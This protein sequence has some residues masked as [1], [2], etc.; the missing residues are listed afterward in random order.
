MDR[1]IRYTRKISGDEANG[2][3]IMVMKDSL[4]LFPKPGVPF[5]IKI[6]DNEFDSQ[7][8]VVD[9]WCQGPKKPHVHY[10]ID[11]TPMIHEFRPHYGQT[12]TLE[13]VDESVYQFVR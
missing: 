6:D 13:K 3:Y 5:K 8:L 1:V 2:R 9:C 4:K 12:V 7:V 11:L 10:R